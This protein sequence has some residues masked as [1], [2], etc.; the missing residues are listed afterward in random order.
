MLPP[1]LYP[2]DATNWPTDCPFYF[3]TSQAISPPPPS[4]LTQS[5]RY[6]ARLRPIETIIATP[7]HQFSPVLWHFAT[8]VTKRSIDE[9]R[10]NRNL[11]DRSRL[12]SN[13]HLNT[14]LL[15]AWLGLPSMLDKHWNDDIWPAIVPRAVLRRFAPRK[16]WGTIAVTRVTAFLWYKTLALVVTSRL[17]FLVVGDRIPCSARHRK[18]LTIGDER[19]RG[20]I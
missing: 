3:Y 14:I 16:R 10:H 18:I 13:Y 4:I 12:P 19:C 2:I 17:T 20:I 8:V 6:P 15:D 7:S 1:L 5:T 11:A 9:T